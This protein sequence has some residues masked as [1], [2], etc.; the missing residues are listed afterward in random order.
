M[1]GPAKTP[2]AALSYG[3]RSETCLR[4][5]ATPEGWREKP[6]AKLLNFGIPLSDWRTLEANARKR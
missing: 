4:P 2:D 3:D 1:A 5:F 6:V